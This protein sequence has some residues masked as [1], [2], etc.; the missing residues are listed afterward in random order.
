MFEINRVHI[1]SNTYVSIKSQSTHW[2][3]NNVPNFS[4]IGKNYSSLNVLSSQNGAE[5]VRIL[6][7]MINSE[8]AAHYSASTRI[9]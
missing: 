4:Q 1:S 5:D 3:L 9:S 7:I 6:F 2:I 8:Y